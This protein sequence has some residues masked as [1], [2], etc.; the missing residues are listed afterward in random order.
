MTG[1]NFCASAW[2]GFILVVKNAA[3]FGTAL[4]IGFIFNFLGTAFITVANGGTVY[5][6]LHYIPMW[7]NLVSNWVPVTIIGGV[8]GF[9]VGVMFMSVFSLA[10]DTILQSF[11]VDEEL[12]RPDGMRP[13]IMNQFVEGLEANKTPS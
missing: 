8:V 12:N 1:K 9:I 5:C 13:A 6:V 2:N 11:M 3:R 10:G 4:A 7:K